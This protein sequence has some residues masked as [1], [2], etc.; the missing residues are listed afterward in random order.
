MSNEITDVDPVHEVAAKNGLT[1]LQYKF[2]EA[3]FGDA[4]GDPLKAMELAGYKHRHTAFVLDALREEI[5]KRAEGYLALNS[6]DAA[7]S[8]VG[9]MKDPAQEGGKLKLDAARD[10]LD[11]IGVKKTEAS[12]GGTKVGIFIFPEKRELDS[13]PV[14]IDGN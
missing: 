8:I 3:L 2:L 6:Y 13:L 14:T 4:D 11:R 9:L 10:I 7:K 5:V 1:V 12:T